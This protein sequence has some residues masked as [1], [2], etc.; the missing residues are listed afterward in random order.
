MSH[1]LSMQPNF[2]TEDF[3]WLKREA[4]KRKVQIM[5]VINDLMSVHMPDGFVTDRPMNEEEFTKHCE[6][7]V[8]DMV[9]KARCQ[10]Q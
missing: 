3:E 7:L 4:A 2:S 1:Y 8:R 10:I 5:D 9:R 6:R